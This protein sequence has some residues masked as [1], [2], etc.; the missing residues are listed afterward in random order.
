MLSLSDYYHA[1]CF[2]VIKT[3]HS[4]PHPPTNPPPLLEDAIGSGG[5][6]WLGAEALSLQCRDSQ[7]ICPLTWRSTQLTL[8]LSSLVPIG[9]FFDFPRPFQAS[10]SAPLAS[11]SR[12]YKWRAGFWAGMLVWLGP[13]GVA[14]W[15]AA[16][17]IYI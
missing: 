2:L 1:F 9:G 16:A 8:G 17:F 3:A 15:G 7:A 11:L 10:F 14:P 13:W 5:C 4:T 6:H 12:G